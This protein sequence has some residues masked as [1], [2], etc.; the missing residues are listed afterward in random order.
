LISY[1]QNKFSLN[2]IISNPRTLY[3]L[4]YGEYKLWN[5]CK[6]CRYYR[7]QV[8]GNTP[9][10]PVVQVEFPTGDGGLEQTVGVMLNNTWNWPATNHL[11]CNP[12]GI[13]GTFTDQSQHK[14]ILQAPEILLLELRLADAPGH[15]RNAKTKA[16][17]Y[18]NI[19]KYLPREKREDENYDKSG[20]RYKFAGALYHSGE[21]LE[22]GHY[23]SVVN[24]ASSR[25][26]FDDTKV[27]TVDTFK[28]LQ[29]CTPCKR[30]DFNPFIY[31][32][33]RSPDA[34][35]K[36]GKAKAKKG[37]KKKTTTKKPIEKTTTKRKETSS[38]KVKPEADPVTP[39]NP[40]EPDDASESAGGIPTSSSRKDALLSATA[41]YIPAPKKKRK[42]PESPL[43]QKP[44]RVKKS[45]KSGR[46]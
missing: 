41:V 13:C 39:D 19:A 6:T 33:V 20:F 4:F 28:E 37:T 9:A 32:Y 46:K 14:R 3:A 22:F 18:I 35:P 34:K 26:L 25:K 38:S 36:T 12:P 1:P 8:V 43:A 11:P 2:N 23:V 24:T 21:G 30:T 29:K 5:E 31:V 17:P 15:K 42:A 10:E 16:L 44:E 7:S 27:T 45:K 40:E